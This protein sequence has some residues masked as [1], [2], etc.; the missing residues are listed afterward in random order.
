M[1]FNRSIDS[2]EDNL[3]NTIDYT[4]V[5]KSIEHSIANQEFNLIETV[6]YEILKIVVGIKNVKSAK[7]CVKKTGIPFSASYAMFECSSSDL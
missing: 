1:E 6:G 2:F 3:D 4:H 7:V 5:I